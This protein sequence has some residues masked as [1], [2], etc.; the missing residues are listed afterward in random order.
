MEWT[1][2]DGK[3][4]PCAGGCHQSF[5]KC[6]KST[7]FC[8]CKRVHNTV[9]MLSIFVPLE[10][11]DF[12]KAHFRGMHGVH[13]WFLC[14]YSKSFLIM[15]VLWAH[16]WMMSVILFLS[17][18]CTSFPSSL[19]LPSH[20][21]TSQKKKKDPQHPEMMVFNLSE[22]LA[23][24]SGITL[25]E[26]KEIVSTFFLQAFDVITES[27]FGYDC[28]SL[29][30]PENFFSKAFT[31]V[32][33]GGQKSIDRSVRQRTMYINEFIKVLGESGYF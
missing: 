4:R 14:Q 9:C 26:G 25:W 17:K 12:I 16:L 28:N 24:N 30:D 21:Q 19:P 31:Y 3:R 13:N 22:A 15:H 23:W 20:T 10:P 27:G 6:S 29:D 18:F 1:G 7:K 5:S 32:L 2:E 8:K 11:L 33:G